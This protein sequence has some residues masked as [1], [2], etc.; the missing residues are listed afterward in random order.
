LS[1]EIDSENFMQDFQVYIDT[2]LSS[3][4]GGP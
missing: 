2:L 4:N 1:L 3:R